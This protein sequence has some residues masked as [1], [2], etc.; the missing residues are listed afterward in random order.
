M[1]F[2]AVWFGGYDYSGFSS[3]DDVAFAIAVLATGNHFELCEV[4]LLTWWF[5]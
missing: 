1:V 4:M 5:K 2:Y 3:L